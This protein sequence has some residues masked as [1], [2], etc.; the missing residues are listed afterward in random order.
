MM[1]LPV[2]PSPAAES[3]TMGLNRLL[4]AGLCCLLLVASGCSRAA[5]EAAAGSGAAEAASG[6][7][8]AATAPAAAPKPAAPA[9]EPVR[10]LT[11]EEISALRSVVGLTPPEPLM[12]SD[13]L[14]RA[15]VREITKYEDVLAEQLLD[16]VAPSAT[17]NSIRIGSADMFGASLQLWRP[18]EAR[19]SGGRFL[20]L[21]ETYIAAA[22]DTAPV[23]DEAFFGEF[24]ETTHY[25]FHHKASRSVAVVTCATKLCDAEKV[26][27]LADRVASRL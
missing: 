4:P 25:A 11:P 27:A 2:G 23:G 12:V 1:A 24:G 8:V 17:Y 3:V 16:G 21:K 22:P 7:G 5:E 18:T 26:K 14:T 9:E 20:R 15:D 10:E 13:L 6:S 19:Q